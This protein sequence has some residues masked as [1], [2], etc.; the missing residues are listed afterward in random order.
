MWSVF[1]S[2]F[3][4]FPF[5]FLSF[6][7]DVC[8]FF[9]CLF[10]IFK[11]HCLSGHFLSGKTL[12]SVS[13]G[14]SRR[15]GTSGLPCTRTRRSA[16]TFGRRCAR[17]STRVS[18]TGLSKRCAQCLLFFFHC[19]LCSFW[20]SCGLSGVVPSLPRYVHIYLPSVFI[21]HK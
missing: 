14:W 12:T 21:A 8:V 5:F 11:R 17:L 20:T 7:T 10:L 9:N 4:S 1:L 15:L 19:L 18:S 3:V 16:T 6:V 13:P 2:F